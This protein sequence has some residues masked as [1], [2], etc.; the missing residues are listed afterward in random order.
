MDPLQQ[1]RTPISRGEVPL[2]R[3]AAIIGYWWYS[4]EN[5][6]EGF[7]KEWPADTGGNS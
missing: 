5:E 7:S 2:L 4:K 6:W 3:R 1:E